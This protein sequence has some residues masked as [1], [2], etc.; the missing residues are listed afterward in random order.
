MPPTR[1]AACAFALALAVAACSGGGDDDDDAAREDDTETSAAEFARASVELEVS[2]AELV[3]PHAAKSFLDVGT[4]DA[5]QD[6]VERLLLIT[7]AGPLVE[8]KAGGG[9]AE[10]FTDDAGA[11]AANAD[12]AVFFDEGVEDF[13]QLT[14]VEAR[15]GM[16]ALAGSMDPKTALVVARYVWTVEG[17]AGDRIARTG[18]LSLVPDGD[19]WRIGAYTIT[20]TRDLGGSSTTTTAT[21]AP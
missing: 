7:S 2:R 6:V 14:P 17:D 4:R 10:L 15:V 20:V 3:S 21:S 19:T 5:V 18:E 9:F 11:R 8:G 12:R 1:L 16:S 13:G